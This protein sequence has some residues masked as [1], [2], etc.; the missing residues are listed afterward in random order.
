MINIFNRTLLFQDPNAE[1]T[2]KICSALDDAGIPYVVKTGGTGSA[3][4]SVRIPRT[5][6][7]GNIGDA[8]IWA[9][10]GVPYSW[11]E[12]G[13]ANTFQSIYV[14]KKDFKK[15]KEICGIA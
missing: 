2:G 3:K 15:A 6:R 13:T 14:Q 9:T 7:T 1:A 8:T 11:M 10:G 12:G 5:G 4:P